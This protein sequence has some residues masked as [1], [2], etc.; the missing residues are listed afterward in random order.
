MGIWTP[1]ILMMISRSTGSMTKITSVPVSL[2]TEEKTIL[3]TGFA[4]MCI[5]PSFRK[6]GRAET[7]H[8][9]TLCLAQR[10]KTVCGMDG[11]QWIPC[12]PAPLSP[13]FVREM[14]SYTNVRPRSVYGVDPKESTRDAK[15]KNTS[16]TTTCSSHY[17]LMMMDY[18]TFLRR[19]HALT[20]P[21]YRPC[22][23]PWLRA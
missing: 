13:S 9:G 10:T 22:D 2:S 14:F 12:V 23:D 1:L 21:R 16:H 20:E 19:I 4:T 11:Q 8:S 18:F 15:W 6:S 17:L 3:A 5:P 7:V